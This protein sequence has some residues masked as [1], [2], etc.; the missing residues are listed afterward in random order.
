[1]AEVLFP[2]NW[3]GMAEEDLQ[4][5]RAELMAIVKSVDKEKEKSLRS[6]SEPEVR[7]WSSC[8]EG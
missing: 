8:K 7:N 1:M 4:K 3:E 6:V 2:D 5:A